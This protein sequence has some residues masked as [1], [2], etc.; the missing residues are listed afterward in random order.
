MRQDGRLANYVAAFVGVW[1]EEKLFGIICGVK[2]IQG[3]IVRE[4]KEFE[5]MTKDTVRRMFRD[6]AIAL[7]VVGYS[8]PYYRERS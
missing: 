8:F 4:G 5:M 1:R 7:L 6:V 2:T 3:L